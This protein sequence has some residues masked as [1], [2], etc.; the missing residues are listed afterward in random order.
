[1]RAAG[2]LNGTVIRLGCPVRCMLLV[3]IAT[4]VW[5]RP[6]FRLSACTTNAGQ[7]LAVRKFASGK[8]TKTTSPRRL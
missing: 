5:E 2:E 3:I 7:R 6:A 8:S 4:I 1:M